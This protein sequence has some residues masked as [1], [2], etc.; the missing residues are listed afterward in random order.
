VRD[1]CVA[2]IFSENRFNIS[3]IGTLIPLSQKASSRR[4]KE[5]AI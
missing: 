2:G 3:G 1:R 4:L 5:S